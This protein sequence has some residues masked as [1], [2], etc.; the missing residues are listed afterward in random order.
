MRTALKPSY[1]TTAVNHMDIP[2][3]IARW[4]TKGDEISDTSS[5]WTELLQNVLGIQNPTQYLVFQQKVILQHV[6]FIDVYIPSTGIIIEQKSSDID[7]DAQARQSDGSMLTPFEQAK[8]YYDWFPASKKGRY[9]IVCNFREIRVHDMETPTAPPKVIPLSDITPQ[10]LAFIVKPE[11]ELSPEER[12]SLKA[13]ELAAKLYASLLKR[14]ND[15]KNPDTLKS[16]NIFCVRIV[17]ILYAEKSGIFTEHQ[18]SDYL[19]AHANTA[20]T[21]IIELFRILRTPDEERDPYTDYDLAAFPYINGGLFEDSGIEIPRIDREIVSIILDDMSVFTWDEINPTIFG[22]L[23]ESTLNPE[24]R[25]IGGMHYTSIQNIH[26]VIDPLFLDGLTAELDSLLK[27]SD[28]TRKKLT[29]FQEKLASLTFLDPACGSGN[30]LTETYLSLR[31]LENRVIEALSHGQRYFVLG[32]LSPIRVSISQF[33]GIE[34]NDFAVS[35]ARTALWIAEHQ[36]M[37]AT[38]KIADF[39]D[40]FIPLKSYSHI[41]EQNAIRT[42]WSTVI[43]PEKLSYIMGNPPFRGARIMHKEQKEDIEA[44]FKSWG[45]LGDFDYVCCWYRKALEF[46]KG[47]KIRAALVST[48]SMNQGD[49]VAMFWRRLFDAGLTIDFAHTPFVWNNE[50]QEKAHVHC[51]VV[52]FSSG[53]GTPQ[54]TLYHTEGEDITAVP[55]KHI[56]AYLIDAPDWWVFNRTLPL[57]EGIPVMRIGCQL[58]DN[59]YYTFTMEEYEEFI[60]REPQAKQYFHKLYGGEEFLYNAPRMCLYLGNCSPHQINMMPLCLKRVEAVRQWRLSSRRAPTRKLAETPARFGSEIFPKGNYIAVP[61]T[62]SERRRYIPMGWLDD[63]VMCTQKLQIIPDAGL[64]HFGVLESL[65]HMAWMRI[66]AGRLEMRYR[67]SS[68]L[69]Y[70]CFVWPEVT[71]EQRA[72]IEETARGILAAR[73]KYP[74]SNLAEL[75]N[76]TLMPVELRHAHRE[77]DEAVRRAYGFGAG[78]SELEIVSRLMEMYRERAGEE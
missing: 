25:K 55:A 2:A 62:S 69:V 28:T 38:H 59:G 49:T 5:F 68:S 36:M 61:Q 39:Y 42:D 57:T 72:E 41:T 9:I 63:S 8:R 19:K 43:P 33:Y 76:E 18:F 46:M 14:C 70:N 58:I 77:N 32:T 31:K 7:L 56:N 64:Y 1:G 40:D 71:G 29:A 34:V 12:I 6:S 52:G 30:F 27:N 11:R 74:D 47:T 66:V 26:R 24:T 51:V 53:P 4:L 45:R 48:N 67:Y 44:F 23:F 50:A 21:S 60:K 65:I 73:E 17:F 22:A 16:L 15:S 37:K 10:N 3:F 20:R 54:K 35:V 75:Y 78:W 13:G